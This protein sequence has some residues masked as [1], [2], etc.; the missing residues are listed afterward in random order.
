MEI[1][2]LIERRLENVVFRELRKT[3]KNVISCA[4]VGSDYSQVGDMIVTDGNGDS[5]IIAWV[6]A[7]NNFCC[8]MGRAEGVRLNIV[9]PSK[10]KESELKRSME[11]FRELAEKENVPIVGGNTQISDKV[12]ESLYSVQIFGKATG[13]TADRKKVVPGMSIVMAG[14]TGMLGTELLVKDNLDI[15]EKRFGRMLARNT[16]DECNRIFKI[17]NCCVNTVVECIRKLTERTEITIPYMHDV[18]A[19]G[20]YTALW[21]LGKWADSGLKVINKKIPIQQQTIEICE[22]L[23]TNPYL[24]DGSGALLLLCDDAE[25]IVETLTEAEITVAVIGRIDAAKE[26]VVL[27]GDDETR[28][29]SAF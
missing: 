16:T 5:P 15:I 7:M 8:S 20:I 3:D 24:I 26:R 12:S 4:S 29:L 10:A 17:E 21:Q 18:S 13:W 28:T 6:K 27:F 22:C 2:N 25:T 11:T 14:L 19:G 1:G 9:L 23:D